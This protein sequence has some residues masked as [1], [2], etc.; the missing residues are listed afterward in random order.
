MN[1]KRNDVNDSS[2][3]RKKTVELNGFDKGYEAEEIVDATDITGELM[4]LMKWKGI[5]GAE[6]VTAKQA[7]VAC[8]QV[9]IAFMSRN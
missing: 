6:L 5:D 8:P 1:T 3:G 4:F 2:K 9:V 7:N